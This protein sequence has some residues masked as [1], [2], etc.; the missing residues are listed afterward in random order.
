MVEVVCIGE[1]DSTSFDI[2]PNLPPDQLF[3]AF[4]KAVGLPNPEVRKD[5][6]DWIKETADGPFEDIVWGPNEEN[7]S[8]VTFPNSSGITFKYADIEEDRIRGQQSN[9]LIND[10]AQEPF[11]IAEYIRNTPPIQYIGS[12]PNLEMSCLEWLTNYCNANW[13]NL[14]VPA[15]TICGVKDDK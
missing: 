8:F 5:V 11:N 13:I 15:P 2:D 3:D 12:D 10:D 14:D 4:T 1:S 9:F 7:S 6:G